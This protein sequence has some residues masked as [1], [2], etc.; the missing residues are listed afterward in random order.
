VPATLRY[1]A[2]VW[3][4]G[5]HLKG[6]FSFRPLLGKASFKIDFEQFEPGRRFYGLRRITL[7]GMVQDRSMIR[8]HEAYWLYARLGV[9]APR[10]GYAEVWVD[11]E[12][13]GL[14]GLIET[15]DGPWAERVFPNDAEGPIYEGGYGVDLEPGD[16]TRF[17]M[18]RQGDL[19]EPWSDLATLIETL[20]ASP[21][22]DILEW[23]DARFDTA[24][25]FRMWAVDLVGGHRDGYVARKNNFLLYHGLVGDQW[26][27]VPWGQ[28]QMFREGLPV[29]G[30]YEGVLAA[31]CAES[32]ACM[33]RLD[34]AMRY[35]L[36]AWE[37]WD[38]HGHAVRTGATVEA[39]CARDPRKELPCGYENELNMILARPDEVREALGW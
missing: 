26:W 35:V 9:P 36:G 25:L 29:H 30:G 34:D 39:A 19:L 20:D 37:A 23:L 27:M 7:N 21:P 28:D 12:L 15:L 33:E 13:Y 4:V 5:L 10:H 2:D 14:Y 31:R 8:E 18:Q 1:G 17:R 6:S 11:G 24:A 22:E 3:T 38:L 16:A 32:P